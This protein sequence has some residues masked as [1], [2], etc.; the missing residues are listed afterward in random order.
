M[1][2]YSAFKKQ[3]ILSFVTWMELKDIMLSEKTKHRETNTTKS[4]LCVESKKVELIEAECGGS[5]L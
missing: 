4:S 2:F 3:E 5:R 1:E